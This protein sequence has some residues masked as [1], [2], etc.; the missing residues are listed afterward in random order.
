M[1][2][3]F[4]LLSLT[5]IATIFLVRLIFAAHERGQLRP[6]P[7]AVALGAVTNFF[8]TLGIGSFAP[9][10]AVFKFTQIR[11]ATIQSTQ[12]GIIQTTSHFLTVTSDKRNCVA[13]IN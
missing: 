2:V 10:T 8:D 5:I 9:T 4:L 3:T 11:Q 6:R 12:L 7:E 1:I 13:I